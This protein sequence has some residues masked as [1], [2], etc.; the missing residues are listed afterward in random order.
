MHA[1]TKDVLGVA[2]VDLGRPLSP[3]VRPLIVARLAVCE[4]LVRVNYVWVG[5]L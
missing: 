3:G 1:D 2:K 4:E 5:Q